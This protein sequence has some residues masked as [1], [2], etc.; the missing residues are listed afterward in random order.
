MPAP[1]SRICG[2]RQS[3]LYYIL[4]IWNPEKKREKKEKKVLDNWDWRWYI[5]KAVAER[6]A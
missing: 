3:N 2:V 6:G 4:C 1:D 5:N